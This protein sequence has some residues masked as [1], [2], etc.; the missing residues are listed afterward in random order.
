MRHKNLISLA[1]GWA[2]GWDKLQWMLL[3]GRKRY[4]E[5]T[6]QP[7]AYIASEKHILLRCMAENGCT[8]DTAGVATLDVL[9]ERFCDFI[10]EEK[11]T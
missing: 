7:V 6:W 5:T 10:D 4:A 3:R 9:P 1:P 8:P 2:L 11:A